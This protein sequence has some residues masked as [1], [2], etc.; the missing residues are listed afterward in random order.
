M[1]RYGEHVHICRSGRFYETLILSLCKV[2]RCIS[3]IEL[4]ILKSGEISMNS[5]TNP[6]QEGKKYNKLL[7]N[8]LTIIATKITGVL[9]INSSAINPISAWLLLHLWTFKSPDFW[10]FISHKGNVT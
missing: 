4:I 1:D 9:Y 8:V 10:Q 5:K 6:L 7:R 3:T 2:G